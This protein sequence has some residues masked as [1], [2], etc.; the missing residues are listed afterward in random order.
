MKAW[1][2][3]KL[4]NCEASSL[5]GSPVHSLSL[6]S[7]QAAP[8]MPSSLFPRAAAQGRQSPPSRCARCGIA[9]PKAV[10]AQCWDNSK[11][12]PPGSLIP[13][14]RLAF[15]LSRSSLLMLLE[16]FKAF[17]TGLRSSG[18]LLALPSHLE[19]SFWCQGI[20]SGAQRRPVTLGDAGCALLLLFLPAAPVQR[21]Q[22]RTEPQ[23]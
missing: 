21:W 13:Q 8:G 15:G 10:P 19:V 2:H 14:G 20:L 11:D 3:P 6:K 9:G 1:T 17:P 22:S 16:C 18:S 12:F 5:L 4:G 7:F 23:Q